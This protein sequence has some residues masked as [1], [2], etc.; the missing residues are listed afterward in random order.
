MVDFGRTYAIVDN[1]EDTPLGKYRW[2]G[3]KWDMADMCY[4]ED[5]VYYVYPDEMDDKQTELYNA[6]KKAIEHY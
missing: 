2:V 6:L 5:A 4:T 1:F 3:K